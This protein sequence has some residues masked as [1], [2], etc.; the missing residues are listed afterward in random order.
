MKQGT[1]L[2]NDQVDEI[3]A[4]YCDGLT[5]D[6]VA[7]QLGHGLSSVHKYLRA[8]GIERR[9]G[10]PRKQE[11]LIDRGEIRQ[12]Y[13]AGEP[14]HVIAR[15][16]GV[17]RP[18]LIR[19][20]RKQGAHI[21]DN[22]ECQQKHSC[23]HR[24]FQI[25]QTEQQAYWLGFFTA[26][27]S[28][29]PPNIIALATALRDGAHVRRFA[30]AVETTCP[31]EDRLNRRWPMTEIAFRSTKMTDDLAQFD[32]VPN[33]EQ[34]VPWPALPSH[35]VR[36][37]LRGEIDGDGS[38]TTSRRQVSMMVASN[39]PYLESCQQFLMN[40]FG[41]KKTKI[42]KA[43]KKVGIHCLRYGGNRQM[44]PFFNWLYE[45]TTIYLPRKRQLVLDHYCGLPKYRD[46]LR[47][48]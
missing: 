13:E 1:A 21:R 2:T 6:Q 15:D 39:R 10:G 4:L 20:L 47:F 12:R 28:I 37:Y 45:G 8:R 27:G 33:K 30:T 38:F 22:S 48:G 19:L 14:A 34:T 23:D 43:G 46:R 17:S 32:V 26:D 16:H 40:E 7:R 35:L 41:F 24:F 9:P 42:Y 3:A 25:I 29:R 18:T 44:L 11:M 5:L 36:H 31:V